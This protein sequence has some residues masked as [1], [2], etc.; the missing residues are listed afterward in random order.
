MT[1]ANE[2]ILL[3]IT[4]IAGVLKAYFEAQKAKAET[5]RA[6]VEAER[7]GEAE[8][9]LKATVESVEQAKID[10]PEAGAKIAERIKKHTQMLGIDQYEELVKEIVSN[11][12]VDLTRKFSKT[13]LKKTLSEDDI[14]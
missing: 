12:K 4:T 7:A 13:R 8:V 11:E 1:I 5:K 2:T 14:A 6:D 9:L 3:I 10:E